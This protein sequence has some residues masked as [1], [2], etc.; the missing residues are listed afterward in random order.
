[1]KQ[2]NIRLLV[3]NENNK[4][5]HA[6]ISKERTGMRNNVRN[7]TRNDKRK[8]K[9]ENKRKEKGTKEKR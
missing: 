5:N 6:L 4:N 7:R 9:S 8:G 2:E 1:M 3:G